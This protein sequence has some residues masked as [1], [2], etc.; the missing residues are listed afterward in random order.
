MTDEE[1]EMLIVIKERVDQ[2]WHRMQFLEKRI[3]DKLVTKQEFAPVRSLVY[4]TVGL[5][6]TTVVL[7]MVGMVVV[8]G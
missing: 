1:H 7:A 4:G 2:I 5:L 3:D 6:L 8:G